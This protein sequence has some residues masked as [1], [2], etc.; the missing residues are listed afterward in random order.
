MKYHHFD[1]ASS[2]LDTSDSCNFY[3]I[4]VVTWKALF[5]SWELSFLEFVKVNFDNSIRDTKDSTE[6][7]IKDTKS[8]HLVAEGSTLFKLSIPEASIEL[9]RQALS[10]LDRNFMR[11]RS[12]SRVI[13]TIITWIQDK[14]K[15]LKA[16]LLIRDIWTTLCATDVAI[17]RYIFWE[18]NNAVDSKLHLLLLSIVVTGPDV[19]MRSSCRPREIF[20]FLIFGAACISK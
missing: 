20:Y 17:V 13:L 11:S 9:P 2:F 5:I 1:I 18:V 4:S 12:S 8:R 14:I 15:K 10:M 3:T 6:Y 16:H 19:K 7:I